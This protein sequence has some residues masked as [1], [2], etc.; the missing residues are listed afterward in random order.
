MKKPIMISSRILGTLSLALGLLGFA[1]PNIPPGPFLFIAAILFL[2]S[3]PCMLA[4]FH[5][6]PIYRCYIDD[7][8]HER[9]MTR[10]N[11]I[12]TLAVGTI[13]VA[14]VFLA[15]K[16]IWAKILVV[17]LMVLKYY[18]IIFCVWIKISDGDGLHTGSKDTNKPTSE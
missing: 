9:S 13:L 2:H 7:F 11:K 5:K 1:Y 15:L 4:R 10:R 14:V 17:I 18:Y 6:M 12:K 8:V 3:S 16:P